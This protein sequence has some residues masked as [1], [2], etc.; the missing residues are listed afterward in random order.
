MI[1]EH[2]RDG[3]PQPVYQRFREKGRMAPDGLNYVSGWIDDKLERC[4]QLMECED[5][6]L[7][8]EWISAWDDIVSFEVFPVMTS[9]A[10]ATRVNG[11]SIS[12][13]E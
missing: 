4:F 10:A 13:H 7:I 1:V 6:K 8:D 5:R 3:D 2:Y 11:M 12:Q 9:A